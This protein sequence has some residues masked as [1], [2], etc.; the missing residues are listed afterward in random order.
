MD[1]LIALALSKKYTDDAISGGGGGG[2]NALIIQNNNGTLDK[3][4]KEIKDAML[5]GTSVLLCQVTDEGQANEALNYEP[6][7]IIVPNDPMQMN[8]Q[9]G[10]LGT[11]AWYSTQDENDYP[12][13]VP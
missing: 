7:T 4:F 12:V 2:G 1:G 6:I 11:Y 10:G 8:Y 5:D 13:Y 3:T 9:V